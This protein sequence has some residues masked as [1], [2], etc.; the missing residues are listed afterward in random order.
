M[1]ELIF[2]ICN[3]KVIND[4]TSDAVYIGSKNF[5][6]A[7]LEAL[8]LSNKIFIDGRYMDIENLAFDYQCRTLEIHVKY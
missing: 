6:I 2:P 8:K 5:N 4:S 1:K 7:E 3:A